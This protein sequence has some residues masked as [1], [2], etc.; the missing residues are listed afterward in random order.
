MKILYYAAVFIAPAVLAQVLSMSAWF[1]QLS[2]TISYKQPGIWVK[3]IANG[4]A[5]I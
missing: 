2:A 1:D 3:E 4:G 5:L